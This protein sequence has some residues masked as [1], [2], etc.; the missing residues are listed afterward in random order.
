MASKKRKPQGKATTKPQSDSWLKWCAPAQGADVQRFLVNPDAVPEPLAICDELFGTDE[1]FYARLVISNAANDIIPEAHDAA[2]HPVP[3]LES[4]EVNSERQFTLSRIFEQTVCILKRISEVWPH[5]KAV[6]RLKNLANELVQLLCAAQEFERKKIELAITMNY[7]SAAAKIE[8]AYKNFCMIELT[9]DIDTDTKRLFLERKITPDDFRAAMRRA[10]MLDRQATEEINSGSEAISLLP[11]DET[12]QT[13]QGL[14]QGLEPGKSKKAAKEFMAWLVCYV[15]CEV[16]TH[17]SKNK[18]LDY[19]FVSAKEGMRLFCECTRARNLLK[20]YHY[21]PSTIQTSAAVLHSHL[22][23][24]R[25]RSKMK[26]PDNPREM[27][28]K[29]AKKSKAEEERQIKAE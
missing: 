15:W 14:A 12:D 20:A 13:F 18:A 27:M 16:P 3:A 22:T 9:G 24:W 29:L 23:S 28:R 4:L 26:W 6:D 19:V 11:Q 5:P 10:F 7:K 21:N 25:K 8:K 17:G 1:L 2:A